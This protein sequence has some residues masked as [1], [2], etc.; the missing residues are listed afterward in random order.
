M[1]NINSYIVTLIQELVNKICTLKICNYIREHLCI[2]NIL[3]G[4][5][6]IHNQLTELSC[7]SWS[8]S[9]VHINVHVAILHT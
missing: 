4:I 2:T 1:N 6:C 9:Y 3:L 8:G 7:N 5:P